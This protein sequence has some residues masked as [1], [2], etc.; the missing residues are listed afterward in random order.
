MRDIGRRE[1]GI[2]F[3]AIPRDVA[4]VWD[5]SVV[6]DQARA[7]TAIPGTA[8]PPAR[9]CPR[10]VRIYAHLARRGDF[11]RFIR[12]SLKGQNKHEKKSQRVSSP[13]LHSLFL[14]PS[15]PSFF[16]IS[17]VSSCPSQDCFFT[18][19]KGNSIIKPISICVLE[20]DLRVGRGAGLFQRGHLEQ[21]LRRPAFGVR[22][23]GRLGPRTSE[24]HEPGR[25]FST[26]IAAPGHSRRSASG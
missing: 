5:K 25:L 15:F 9:P 13:L 10:G 19:I 6:A 8:N 16:S 2:F 20:S 23:S 12:C 21:T 3:F 24:V 11:P 17:S 18:A 7:P 14:L 26:P 4:C 1:R 22:R